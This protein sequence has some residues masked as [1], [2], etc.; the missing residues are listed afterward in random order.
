MFKVK[1]VHP[2]K[3]VSYA[4]T[5]ENVHY[6]FDKSE[7]TSA[8]LLMVSSHYGLDI[9]AVT[10]LKV[11]AMFTFSFTNKIEICKLF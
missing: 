2:Y 7:R 4:V 11:S 8:A 9:G 1:K 10:S 6:K 3:H 5:N